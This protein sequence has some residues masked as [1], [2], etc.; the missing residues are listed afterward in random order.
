MSI[1]IQK[2]LELIKKMRYLIPCTCKICKKTFSD[3]ILG[4]EHIYEEHKKREKSNVIENLE[5]NLEEDNRKWRILKEIDEKRNEILNKLRDDESIILSASVPAIFKIGK[6]KYNLKN[7]VDGVEKLEKPLI[8]KIAE[9]LK[10]RVTKYKQNLT[11]GYLIGDD[12][13]APINKRK[14]L[15]LGNVLQNILGLQK[16]YL[17]LTNSG[18]KKKLEQTQKESGLIAENEEEEIPSE[19]DLEDEEVEL[20]E[21]EDLED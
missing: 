15:K 5:W 17:L 14:I 3:L 2:R 1:D 16:A 10:N 11:D 19:E 7:I 9:K 20:E 6:E 13:V 18:L 8:N 4:E 21:N 12:V